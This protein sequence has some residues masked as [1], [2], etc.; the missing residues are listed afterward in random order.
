MTTIGGMIRPVDER[1]LEMPRKKVPKFV[2]MHVLLMGAIRR[3]DPMIY[4]DVGKANIIAF[5]AQRGELPETSLEALANGLET[6]LDE[7]ARSKITSP[8][9]L[10]MKILLGQGL[11]AVRERI[12]FSRAHP[13]MGAMHASAA[14]NGC[15]I[16]A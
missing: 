11:A 15:H 9:V 8:H 14:G 5:I 4:T 16:T 6:K 10:V 13:D 12:A 2:P 3:I 1:S 7:L